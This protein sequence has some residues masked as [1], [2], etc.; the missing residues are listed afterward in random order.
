L[1]NVYHLESK[2]QL[3]Q[4]KLL[5]QLLMQVEVWMDVIQQGS[6]LLMRI[7]RRQEMQI[8]L[9]NVLLV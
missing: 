6:T 2:I 1:C 7:V 8:Q 3:K 5:K 9:Q 4:R